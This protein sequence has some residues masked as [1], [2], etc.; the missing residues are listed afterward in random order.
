[1]KLLTCASVRRRLTAFHDRELPVEDFIAVE[2]HLDSCPPC[3]RELAALDE[4]ARALRTCARA[5]DGEQGDLSGLRAD[6]LSRLKAER[7]ASLPARLERFWDDV[8]LVWI[9]M[10]AAAATLVCAI[11]LTGLMQFASPAR[12]D[13][14]L[15]ALIEALAAAPSTEQADAVPAS[16]M[17]EDDAV[18][19]LSAMM[20]RERVGGIELLSNDLERQQVDYLLN[21]IAR[22]RGSARVSRPNSLWLFAQTTVRGKQRL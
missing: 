9:G 11:F 5:S 12:D 7:D 2:A 19:A 20:S 21:S 22:A 16:L 1:M 13:N 10:A 14:S 15:A 6:I 18:T 17:N 4:L 3:A 8:H